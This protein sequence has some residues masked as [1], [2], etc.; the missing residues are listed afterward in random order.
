MNE[1]CEENLCAD[2]L[3]P[4]PA[5]PQPTF[6]IAVARQHNLADS[7]VEGIFFGLGFVCVLLGFYWV[8]QYHLQQ[9]QRQQQRRWWRQQQQQREEEALAHIHHYSIEYQQ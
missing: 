4:Q 3:T 6:P 7:F 2:P 1:Y 9:Q 8:L 5:P